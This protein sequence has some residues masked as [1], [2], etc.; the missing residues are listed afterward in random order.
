MG[1]IAKLAA[2]AL[3]DFFPAQDQLAQMVAADSILHRLLE[4]MVDEGGHADENV[5]LDFLD[6]A[7]IAF[8]AQ[9]LATARAETKQAESRRSIMHSPEGQVARVGKHVQ[10]L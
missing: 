10:E 4:N 9:H 3:G 6:Q 8:G 2:D 7:Q 1:E 5:G